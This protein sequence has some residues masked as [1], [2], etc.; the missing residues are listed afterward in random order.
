MKTMTKNIFLSFTIML[1]ANINAAQLDLNE[2][3]ALPDT[4]VSVTNIKR[5]IAKDIANNYS[6]A[7]LLTANIT[8]SNLLVSS[9]K[10][11]TS[12]LADKVALSKYNNMITDLKGLNYD[13]ANLIQ[14]RLADK[15]MI[16]KLHQ[17]QMPLFAF[18]P[19]GNDKYWQSIEAFD[20][21][22]NVHYLD[23]VNLPSN[24]TFIIE[25]D[26]KKTF[27]A[28]MSVM[29]SIFSKNNT[30]SKNQTNTIARNEEQPIST[31]VLKKIRL[32]DD[33]EPWISGDAEIYA[34]V[35]GVNPSRDEPILDILDMPYLD[36]DNKDYHPNQI[37]IHWERYRWQAADMILMEQDDNTNYKTLASKFLEIVEQV[38]KSIPDPEVQGYAIIPKLTNELLK[39]MPDSWFTNDDDYVD[40]FYT[41]FENK[42]YSNQYGASGNAKVTIEPLMINPR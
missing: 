15:T 35:T 36:T 38:M 12:N 37:I 21:H 23:V 6:T 11:G 4:K 5:Q 18:E 26:S 27:T 42:Y 2:T 17:G 41:L 25:L 8:N 28:G 40:V 34:I 19:A 39:A 33:E 10:L 14:L 3:I 24:P 20:T 22:G 16:D 31:S 32:N 30:Q 29:K 1:G 9:D 7:K 13:N